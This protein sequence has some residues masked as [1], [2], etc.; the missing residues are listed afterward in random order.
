MYIAPYTTARPNKREES[1][2]LKMLDDRDRDGPTNGQ[3]VQGG[4]KASTISGSMRVKIRIPETKSLLIAQ[5][6]RTFRGYEL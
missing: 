6:A 5:P 4:R 3:Y 1:R 2:M